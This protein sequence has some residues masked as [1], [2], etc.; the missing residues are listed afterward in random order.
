[1]PKAFVISYSDQSV[2]QQV[3]PNVLHLR[4]NYIVSDAA[5]GLGE[6]GTADVAINLTDTLAQ[7][8]NRIRVAI[9]DDIKDHLTRTDLVPT[10]ADIEL[11]SYT[12]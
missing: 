7:R 2:N 10:L 1:M 9:R 12:V 6:V 11:I 3:T 4:A 5:T 8:A